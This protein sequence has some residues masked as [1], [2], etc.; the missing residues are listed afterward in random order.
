MNL[1]AFGPM[2]E[3]QEHYR[4]SALAW[5]DYQERLK[6][7]NALMMKAARRGFEL[8]E[9]KLSEREQPGRQIDSLRGLYDLWVDAAEEGYAEVALSGEFRDAYGALVNAQMRVRAQLRFWPTWPKTGNGSAT[10][11]PNSA[12][13]H[14]H[15]EPQQA[16]SRR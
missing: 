3:H 5:I 9:G 7:Y 13:R 12:S 14:L 11:S 16:W 8:F 15:G 2:R 1:P 10:L 4:D 6:R